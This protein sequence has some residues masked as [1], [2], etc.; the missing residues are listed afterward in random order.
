M[1]MNTTRSTSY[2]YA[3]HQSTVVFGAH[4]T[5]RPLWMRPFTR[6][7]VPTLQYDAKPSGDIRQVR[8][9]QVFVPGTGLDAAAGIA[10]LSPDGKTTGTQALSPEPANPAEALSGTFEHYLQSGFLPGQVL[11]VPG[12]AAADGSHWRIPGHKRYELT[13]HLGNVRATVTDIRTSVSSA[14]AT[15]KANV[16][17]VADY[18]PFGMPMPNRCGQIDKELDKNNKP[19]DVTDPYKARKYRFGYN[20]MEKDNDIAGSGNSY[21]FGARMYDARIGRF[22]SID[23]LTA[24]YPSLNPYNF[25]ANNPV[26]YVDLDGKANTLF[27]YI[28]NGKNGKS[29]VNLPIAQ[30]MITYVNNT[31]AEAGLNIKAVL[32]NRS[33]DPADLDGSDSFIYIAENGNSAFQWFSN[34]KFESGEKYKLERDGLEIPSSTLKGMYADESSLD[35]NFVAIS[36]QRAKSDAGGLHMDLSA[37]LAYTVT[38]GAGHNAGIYHPDEYENLEGKEDLKGKVDAK[39][40]EIPFFGVMS[41]GDQA[42]HNA[43]FSSYYRTFKGLTKLY[44]NKFN[45]PESRDNRKLN[46]ANRENNTPT[47]PKYGNRKKR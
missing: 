1:L 21:D 27:I 35:G 36:L 25:V 10:A 31:F 23:P 47:T 41:S 17:S 5:D 37:Y 15:G 11:R 22:K 42:D 29:V 9:M 20:G 8:T 18:Y 7:Y 43:K 46:K 3:Q 12:T 28:E 16:T 24:N 30:E 32:V 39:D 44:K 19:G 26:I 4:K 40:D 38:H 2:Q 13:D 14:S 33:V 34:Q 45:S 6:G